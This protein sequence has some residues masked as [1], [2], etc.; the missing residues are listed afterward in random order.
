[1]DIASLW[2]HRAYEKEGEKIE[3]YHDHEERN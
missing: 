3:K 2:D 1:M